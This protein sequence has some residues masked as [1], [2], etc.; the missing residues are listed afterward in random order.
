MS[1][2]LL[3]L[4]T[5]TRTLLRQTAVAGA[6]LGVSLSSGLNLAHAQE[7]RGL[8]LDSTQLDTLWPHW[9][10]RLGL[11]LNSGADPVRN[12]YAL[13]QN[14]GMGLKVHS[15]HLLSD[16]Y[17]SGGFRATAG[18]VRGA[19]NLPWW[20]MPPGEGSTHMS[21]QRVD[22][23][24]LA[25]HPGL[26]ALTESPHRTVPYVGAGYSGRL[27]EAAGQGAWHF[28]ADLGLISL[29]SGNI[30]RISRVLQGD[31]GVDELVRELRLRPVLKFSVNYAF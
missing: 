3:A 15:M 30:G 26:G 23:M 7:G 28:N 27:T 21:L 5:S 29:N 4:T 25:G 18:L 14:E 17:F 24:G 12:P 11:V 16:Y 10:G 22:V 6:L 20:T 9:E 13:S 1:S 2:A 8:A 19:T 31:Q